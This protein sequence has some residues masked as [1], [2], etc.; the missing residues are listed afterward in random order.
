MYIIYLYVYIY[1]C[2][3]IDMNIYIYTYTYLYA[4][5]LYILY[6]E[7]YIACT[8]RLVCQAAAIESQPE[9][10]LIESWEDLPGIEEVVRE[11]QE[12]PIQQ[13]TWLAGDIP[14]GEL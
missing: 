7:R 12:L 1:I 2:I 4:N 3:H 8:P 6:I 13:V 11:A 14:M 9:M 5:M 10:E